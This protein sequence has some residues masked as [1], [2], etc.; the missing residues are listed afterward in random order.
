MEWKEGVST[1]TDTV[2]MDLSFVRS[3]C[4]EVVIQFI[5]TRQMDEYHN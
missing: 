2:I 4:M 1:S 3:K 5:F